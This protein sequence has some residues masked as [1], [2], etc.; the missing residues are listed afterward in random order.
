MK[1]TKFLTVTFGLIMIFTA[2]SV[3]NLP[4]SSFET[5]PLPTVTETTRTER[6]TTTPPPETSAEEET[7]AETSK[8]KKAE[9]KAETTAKATEKA[10]AKATTAPPETTAAKTTKKDTEALKIKE[11]FDAG[12]SD[13]WVSGKGK[14]TRILKDDNDG[15]RHQRFIL[16]LS[17][18]QTLLI[19]HNIDI[20]PRLD[21]LDEGDTVSFYGEYYWSDEGGGVH[22]T[23]HD[24]DGSSDGGWLSWGGKTYK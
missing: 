1:I 3:G 2:C 8:T 21:G 19:A 9:T 12:K 16:E 11:L 10:T 7:E 15:D 18:G 17:T 6:A 13:V 22:W 20:A 4:E 5:V 24:P 14:V 23:H